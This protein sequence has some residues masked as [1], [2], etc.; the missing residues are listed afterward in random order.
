MAGLSNL[1]KSQQDFFK[2]S[3]DH[4]IC[5]ILERYLVRSC[6]IFTRDSMSYDAQL[7]IITV[8]GAKL[9]VTDSV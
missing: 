6:K 8:E 9:S 1:V 4:T 7:Y 3:W 2:I 5:K